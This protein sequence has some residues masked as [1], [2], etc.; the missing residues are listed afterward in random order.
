HC[1][2]KSST[3]VDFFAQLLLNIFSEEGLVLIDSGNDEVRKI[4]S[5]H[6]K[7][8]INKQ[9]EIATNVYKTMK[10]LKQSGYEIPLDISRNDAHLFYLHDGERILLERTH[11]GGWVGKNNEIQLTTE[12]MYKIAEER[13]ELLSNNVITRPL[14]QE[15]LFPTLAFIGGNGEIS[16]WAVLKDAFKSVHINMPPIMPRLSFTYVERDIK[17]LLDNYSIPVEKAINKGVN[18]MKI[19]WLGT[20]RTP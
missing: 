2:R 20:K 10:K 12:Q 9:A 13:P 14:M 1:L 6:F 8:V 4:E 18:V 11:D 19:N 3:Y 17:K 16:Y 15:L 5:K 7:E